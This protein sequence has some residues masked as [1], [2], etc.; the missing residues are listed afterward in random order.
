MTSQEGRSYKL[1]ITGRQMTHK[2]NLTWNDVHERAHATALLIARFVKSNKLNPNAI[3][4]Y[5]VPD[6]GVPAALL[7]AQAL[8]ACE[9]TMGMTS[10]MA[11]ADLIIDDLEDSGDTRR[12]IQNLLADTHRCPAYFNLYHKKNEGLDGVWVVFPWEDQ[13]RPWQGPEESVE[14]PQDA[15]TRLL[16]YIGE[17]PKREGLVDTP[18]RVIKSFGEIYGGYKVDPSTLLTVFEDGA[19]D[20]MVVLKDI[21]FHSCC[22]HHMQPFFG[23]A[24][25]AY[26]PDKRVIGVSKLA[27]IL[28][29]YARRLQVQER[30]TQQVV[31]ALMTHLQ[32]KGA[33]CVIEAQH[34]CMVCRG[35]RKQNSKMVTS[36]MQG[37]FRENR[38]PARLELL[39][40][41][42]D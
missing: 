2:L 11:S 7:V 22:E 39:E 5:A 16:Q 36:S 41:L 20:E 27:R 38:N 3:Q 42:R 10:S 29:V 25:I 40:L 4:C 19:C 28:D 12:A 34:F 15:V 6:G 17:D 9:I 26:V 23:K 31:D 30:L 24:A 13:P 1:S 32:P 18:K 37:V 14:G 35:V 8:K 33:A 21:E